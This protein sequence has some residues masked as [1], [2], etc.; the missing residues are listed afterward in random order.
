LAAAKT[1]GSIWT[2]SENHDP[3]GRVKPVGQGRAGWLGSVTRL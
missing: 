3:A 2:K 1:A